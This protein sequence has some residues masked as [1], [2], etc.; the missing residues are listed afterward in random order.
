MMRDRKRNSIHWGGETVS[1]LLQDRFIYGCVLW[2][3]GY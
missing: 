2:Q 3:S 1:K